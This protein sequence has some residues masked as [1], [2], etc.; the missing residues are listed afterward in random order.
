M[1]E[2]VVAVER[3]VNRLIVRSPLN[4]RVYLSSALITSTLCSWP[5]HFSIMFIASIC[6]LESYSVIQ[7]YIESYIEFFKVRELQKRYLSRTTNRS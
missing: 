4:T 6:M 7:F 3:V 5:F 2:L 1:F